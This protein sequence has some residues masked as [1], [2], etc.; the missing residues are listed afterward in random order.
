MEKL[1]QGILT[2]FFRNL[3]GIQPDIDVAFSYNLSGE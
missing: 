3:R 2:A 1:Q